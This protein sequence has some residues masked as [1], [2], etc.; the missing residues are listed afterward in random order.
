M[1]LRVAQPLLKVMQKVASKNAG[2]ALLAG[3]GDMCVLDLYVQR[4]V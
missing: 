2:A 4:F 1:P 3:G